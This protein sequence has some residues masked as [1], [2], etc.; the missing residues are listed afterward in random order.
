M[1]EVIDK[2]DTETKDIVAK[3]IKDAQDFA[4]KYAEEPDKWL[5]DWT[6]YCGIIPLETVISKAKKV[7]EN[8]WES[9]EEVVFSEGSACMITAQP[10]WVSRQSPK[11]DL[12]DKIGQGQCVRRIVIRKW[13]LH[14]TES[15]YAEIKVDMDGEVG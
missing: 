10:Q 14:I 11:I 8:E 13:S 6:L 5:V 1:S 15:G 2:P 12:R 9:V 4:R 7:G 3:A